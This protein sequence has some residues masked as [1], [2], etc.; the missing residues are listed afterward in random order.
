MVG[1]TVEMRR[2]ECAFIGCFWSNLESE[3]GHRSIA[4]YLFGT[5]HDST[6]EE[7]RYLVAGRT[8]IGHG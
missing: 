6:R 8:I 1:R 5:V 7:S 2:R 3:R 4:M